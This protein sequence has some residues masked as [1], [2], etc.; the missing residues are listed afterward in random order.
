MSIVYH[1]I[2]RKCLKIQWERGVVGKGPAN[3]LQGYRGP[4]NNGTSGDSGYL[5]ASNGLQEVRYWWGAS[6]HMNWVPISGWIAYGTCRAIGDTNWHSLYFDSKTGECLS[7]NKNQATEKLNNKGWQLFQE[8]KYSEAAEYFNNAY[9]ACSSGYQNEQTFKNNIDKAKAELDAINLNS[10]GDN[11]FNQGKYHEAHSKYQEAYDKSQ[12]ST[13]YNKYST[14]RDKAKAELDA[15]N[16]NSQGDNLFNQGRYH[17]AHSKYQEAYDKSQVSTQYNKYSTNRDK[18]KTELDAINLNSQGDN[19]FNQGR[20]HE[21]HSK[22]QEAYDKSQVSTQYNKYSTNRDK[23]KTELDAINLNSQGDNLFNQGR[24]HEAHSKYQEAYDKSQVSTQYNKYSTNRDKAKTELDAINLNS[25]GDNLFNQGRHHEAH[26]KYQE[27]YDK[28]QVSTQYNK[29][30]T[31]RDKAKTEL[32]AINLN[33][34]GDNLFNQG[35]YHEAHSKYQEAYDKSQVNTQYNKYSTNRDKAKAELNAIGLKELGDI[36]FNAGRYDSAKVKYQEA[37]NK[38]Q[39][40]KEKNKY[41]ICKDKVKAELN[42]IG[43]KE[44]GDVEFNVGRYDSAK[45]KYQEAFNKSSVA[46]HKTTYT[47]C[48]S[49]A[50][51]ELDAQS[52]YQCGKMLFNQGKYSDALKEYQAAHSSSKVI[53]AKSTYNDEISKVKVEI[54]AKQLYEQGETLYRAGNYVEAKTKYNEAVYTSEVNKD[55]Y[56]RTGVAK[57]QVELNA[58]ELNEQG[59]TLFASGN[60]SAAKDKYQ[61]AYNISEVAKKNDNFFSKL[62]YSPHEYKKNKDKAQTELDAIA[63]SD[64]ANVFLKQGKLAEV[65]MKYQAAYDKTQI[66][67]QRDQYKNNRDLIQAKVYNKEGYQLLSEASTRGDLAVKILKYKNA[68]EKFEKAINICPNSDV[69][70]SSLAK[71]KAELDAINLNSQGDNLFDQGRYHESHNKYQEAYNKSQITKE[72]NKYAVNQEKAQTIINKL[73]K[74]ETLWDNAWKA[75]NDTEDDRSE[76]AGGFLQEV[77]RESKDGLKIVP[78]DSKFKQYEILVSL[79]MEGNALFNEGLESQQDGLELLQEAHKLKQQQKYDLANV[80]FYEAKEK[81]SNAKEKFEIGSNEDQRFVSCV[82][83]VQKQLHEVM[84]SLEITE[85]HTLAS[86]LSNLDINISNISYLE[87]DSLETNIV[88]DHNNYHAQM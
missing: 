84:A 18:A 27:A 37:Y 69:Y 70:K 85:Q 13:Q 34:Q 32:D 72:K 77:L 41:T 33:S 51:V 4:H 65:I 20:Y 49:K 87:T 74:L 11:L 40:T 83:F 25:Q 59:N 24:Y 54:S 14:N 64:Q 35:R 19:L 8:G 22:Y 62:F 48:I 21:A 67:N 46:A 61:Q 16:L 53:N 66:F 86:G 88:G 26:S 58:I 3:V 31:N 71:V 29:Y 50:Q 7:H 6:K 68:Q 81:F 55:Y 17:E 12:V 2:Y 45:V 15:I 9:Q 47:N 5:G 36:E 56:S 44:L 76:E 28:S 23:A 52:A 57:A 42:A 75:E 63:L 1:T 43:L 38:S 10:Q 79:K 82:E 60:F 78:N 73:L 39:I 30:S 80:K